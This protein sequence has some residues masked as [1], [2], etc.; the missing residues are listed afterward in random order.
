MSTKETLSVKVD[1]LFD[2][3]P[4]LL[5]KHPRKDAL[6]AKENGKWVMRTQHYSSASFGGVHQTVRSD[7][8]EE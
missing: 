3:L 4:A 6:V 1:R 7:F 2:A 5:K 8:E